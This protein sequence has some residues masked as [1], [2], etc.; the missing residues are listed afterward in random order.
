[1]KLE[2]LVDKRPPDLFNADLSEDR[3]EHYLGKDVVAVDTET[4]GLIGFQD[5]QGFMPV[6]LHLFFNCSAQFH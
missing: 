2:A 5:N 6:F 3:L 1:L 4:R